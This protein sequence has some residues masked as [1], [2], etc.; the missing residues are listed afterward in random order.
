MKVK[1]L[2]AICCPD[3]SFQAGAEP[4]LS[5]LIANGLIC[6]GYAVSL[7]PIIIDTEKPIVEKPIVVKPIVKKPVSIKK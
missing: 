4:N 1:L 6:G 3:G 5:D 2:K 7:E